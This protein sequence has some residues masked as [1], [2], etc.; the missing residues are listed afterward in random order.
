MITL[1]LKKTKTSKSPIYDKTRTEFSTSNLQTQASQISK[2]IF[3]KLQSINLQSISLTM[4][5]MIAIK[6]LLVA[7]LPLS[8]KIYE[9]RIKNELQSQQDSASKVLATDN[10]K[11]AEVTETIKKYSNLQKKSAEYESKKK[12]IKQLTNS[13]LVI[14]QILDNIQSNIPETVW[15]KK[16]NISLEKNKSTLK[17]EGE[18]LSEDRINFF[19]DSLKNL[20]ERSDIKVAT[21]D[22]KEG[23][24]TLKVG[25]SLEALL[26]A[27]RGF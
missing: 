19:A 18:S 21:K 26:F 11:L 15:L 2:R 12:F 1:N 25:F 23:I 7:A 14:P 6:I 13:R 9:L 16:I 22:I 3:Q 17:I 27:R 20:G 5:F 8:L 4:L 10:A 24:N